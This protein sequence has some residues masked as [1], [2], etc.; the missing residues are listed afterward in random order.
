MKKLSEQLLKNYN[1]GL[2]SLC[3]FEET[4][5]FII[6]SHVYI[7]ETSGRHYIA[8]SGPRKS[9]TEAMTY[10]GYHH[11]YLSSVDNIDCSLIDTL[12]PWEIMGKELLPVGTYVEHI[13]DCIRKGSIVKIVAHD[14]D[15][16]EDTGYV[17]SDS[18]DVLNSPS[19]VKPV[20]SRWIQTNKVNDAIELLK[21]EGVLVEGTVFNSV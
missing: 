18:E 11:L 3:K 21:R 16:Y 6:F 7:E 20:L 12:Q 10:V 1:H 2:L 17:L 4:D 9:I 5:K 8:H 15:A 19:D 14:T 13:R